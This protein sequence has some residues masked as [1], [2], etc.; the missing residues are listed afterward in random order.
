MPRSYQ[1]PTLKKIRRGTERQHLYFHGIL[2]IARTLHNPYSC[3]AG[4]YFRPQSKPKELATKGIIEGPYPTGEDAGYITVNLT[5]EQIKAD[6][7]NLAKL[8]DAYQ[9]CS[10]YTVLKDEGLDGLIQSF[11]ERIETRDWISSKVKRAATEKRVGL[12]TDPDALDPIAI[13]E[14]YSDLPGYMQA[15]AFDVKYPSCI[16]YDA[17]G[18]TVGHEMTHGFDSEGYKTDKTGK[19]TSFQSV[20]AT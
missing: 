11:G 18:C 1:I 3:W 17:A 19:L 13:E 12:P 15:P 7:T 4:S 20:L 5:K 9:V 14:Y 2:T 6:K 10:N 8:Q 16:N